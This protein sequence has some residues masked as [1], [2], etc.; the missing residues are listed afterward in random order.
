[1]YLHRQADPI[2][3]FRDDEMRETFRRGGLSQRAHYFVAFKFRN[4]IAYLVWYRYRLMSTL[5][6]KEREE[7]LPTIAWRQQRYLGGDPP[8][9][10]TDDAFALWHP[11]L[12]AG[13]EVLQFLKKFVTT[14]RKIICTDKA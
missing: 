12:F 8:G 7:I 6:V 4:P 14:P 10:S 11:W 9:M 13:M 3:D 1:M 2:Y 5:T